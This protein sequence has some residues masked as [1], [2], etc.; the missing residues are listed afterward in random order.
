M[1]IIHLTLVAIILFGLSQIAKGAEYVASIERFGPTLS[2]YVEYVEEHANA[3]E[4]ANA[5]SY[6]QGLRHM[7]VFTFAV[8]GFNKAQEVND[9]ITYDDMLLVAAQ[10]VDTTP[11]LVLY[12]DL[13]LEEMKPAL[14]DNFLVVAVHDILLRECRDWLRTQESM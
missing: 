12:Q 4:Q 8:E 14:G 11:D 5:L 13:L 10:C 7:W 2:G 1:R 6:L 9:T 3:D